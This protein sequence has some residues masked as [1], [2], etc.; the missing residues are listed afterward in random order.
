MIYILYDTKFC[1]KKIP[2]NLANCNRFT[3]ICLSKISSL[4]TIASQLNVTLKLNSILLFYIRQQLA[5]QLVQ[6]LYNC[7]SYLCCAVFHPS[8]NEQL[9]QIDYRYLRSVYISTNQCPLVVLQLASQLYCSLAWS[10]TDFVQGRY[11]LHVYVGRLYCKRQTNT[12][13]QNQGQ[14]KLYSIIQQTVIIC[15]L[16]SSL[17]MQCGTSGSQ[18]LARV[19]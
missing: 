10:N 8:G 6:H 14:T 3:K 15:L 2:V 4:Y 16:W 9:Y 12:P 11:H 18:I 13:A 5:S 1:R 7:F 19:R 17:A